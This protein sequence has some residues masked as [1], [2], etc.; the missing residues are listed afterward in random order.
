MKKYMKRVGHEIECREQNAHTFGIFQNGRWVIIVSLLK[1]SGLKT[2]SGI[3][4]TN[5]VLTCHNC[6]PNIDRDIKIYRQAVELWND[7]HKRLNYNDLPDVLKIHKNRIGP[8]PFVKRWEY[9][10]SLTAISLR[11]HGHCSLYR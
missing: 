11:G 5:D 2:E 4:T 8:L 1:K 6:R 7:G 9:N 10:C 3:R